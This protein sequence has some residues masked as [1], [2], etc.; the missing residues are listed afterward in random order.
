MNLL[1]KKKI[2]LGTWSW[3]NK[4]FWDYKE[5]A[6]EELYATFTEA[7]KSGFSLIDTA[8]SYG[9][10]R[11]VGRSEELI[12]SFLRKT[13]NSL[14]SKIK[15]ATKLAPYPWRI[16]NKGFNI[17]FKNSLERLNNK[18]DIVQ[19]HWSTSKYNP[20]Q[21]FQLLNN[22]CDLNDDG[23]NF[24]IGL[25]NIG[26]QR[27]LKII[28]FLDKRD[29]RV[30]TVQVQFSLLTPE[31]EK[32]KLVKSICSKY[33]ID[34]LAYSPLSF[35][36]LCQDPAVKY[37]RNGS[38]LRNY[39]FQ[40]Y[41]KSTINLRTSIKNIADKRGVTQAQVAVNWCCYQGA[42]PIVGLRK[43]SQVADISGI[44]NWDLNDKEFKELESASRKTLKR[45][46]LNFL[47]S[48]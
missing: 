31:Y 37:Q 14:A 32:Q 30:K 43:K 2:A 23:Y 7:L 28:D 10:G 12:G 15:I 48:S 9:T 35:G 40:A 11:L 22:L 21:D 27:L 3:G 24:A 44:F 20:F 36:I 18:L 34:F 29:K 42:I 19:L 8:D 4:L 1:V 38:F 5:N 16:G 46:P 39:I 25:S 45:M 26:P 47:S 13:P 17:P 6:D 33:K 41:E